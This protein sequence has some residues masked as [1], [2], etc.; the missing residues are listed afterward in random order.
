M[1][2]SSH[3][4]KGLVPEIVQATWPTRQRNRE[5]S[6]ALRRLSGIG[7]YTHKACFAITAVNFSPRFTSVLR[8]STYMVAVTIRITE[9]FETQYCWIAGDCLSQGDKIFDFPMSLCGLKVDSQ[10]KLFGNSAAGGFRSMY[11][12]R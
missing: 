7:S 2:V 3:D 1:A 11:H 8:A 6:L 9:T 5:A 10:S 12:S 4:G